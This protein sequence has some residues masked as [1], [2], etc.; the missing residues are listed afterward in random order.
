MRI[1]THAASVLQLSTFLGGDAIASLISVVVVVRE[2]ISVLL[3]DLGISVG[4]ADQVG[5]I[6]GGESHEGEESYEG[7]LKSKY[8]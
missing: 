4:A 6:G 5:D 8:N 3:E 2:D 1:Y 7:F